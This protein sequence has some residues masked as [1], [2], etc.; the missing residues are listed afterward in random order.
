ME[1]PVAMWPKD[2][3]Y[4]K[5]YIPAHIVD[6]MI[7][8]RKI[9]VISTLGERVFYQPEY[10]IFIRNGNKSDKFPGHGN[11]SQSLS[12]EAKSLLDAMFSYFRYLREVMIEGNRI[13]AIEDS[14]ETDMSYPLPITCTFARHI[15]EKEEFP[16]ITKQ[17]VMAGKWKLTE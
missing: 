6:E 16:G 1:S 13:I 4:L 5:T 10:C 17:M 3:N 15:E 12:P 14:R 7:N 2:I 9:A 8:N 11:E